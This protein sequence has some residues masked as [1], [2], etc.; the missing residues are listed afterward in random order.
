MALGVHVSLFLC[1]KKE[2]N[3]RLILLGAELDSIAELTE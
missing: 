3:E 2:R 1:P